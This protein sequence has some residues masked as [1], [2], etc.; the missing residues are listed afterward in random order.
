M[1]NIENVTYTSVWDGGFE[2]VTGAKYNKETK[3]VFDIKESDVEI[4]LLENLD[5][6]YIELS[7]GSILEVEELDGDYYTI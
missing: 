7:N 3:E 6:E 5:S 1:E 4:E 2:V